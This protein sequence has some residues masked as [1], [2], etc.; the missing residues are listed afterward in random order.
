MAAAAKKV[1]VVVAH[2]SSPMVAVA[3]LVTNLV[4]RSI[5]KPL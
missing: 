3:A 1:K 4:P 5:L 2:S